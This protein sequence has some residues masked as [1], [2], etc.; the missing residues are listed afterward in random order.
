MWDPN[1]ERSAHSEPRRPYAKSNLGQSVRWVKSKPSQL[2]FQRVLKPRANVLHR[3]AHKLW[4][5]V[6]V[7]LT[8][9]RPNELFRTLQSL[10]D[11]LDV[12]WQNT[13]I[14]VNE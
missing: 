7:H 3:F 13:A 11:S 5:I 12:V 1:C 14:A 4:L 2:I 9:V 8:A 6:E 10:V